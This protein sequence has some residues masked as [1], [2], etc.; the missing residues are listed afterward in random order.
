MVSFEIKNCE[1]SKFVFFF[2]K[3]LLAILSPLHFHINFRF[4]LSISAK[5]KSN[6]G[7]KGI[8]LNLYIN[9]ESITI[10]T[11]LRLL[12]QE[13]GMSHLGL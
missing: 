13:H 2:F 4:S 6:W 8:A 1:S 7:S 9:L 11:I 12:V 10:L 3:I 5:K